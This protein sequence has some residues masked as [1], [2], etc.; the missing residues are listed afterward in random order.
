MTKGIKVL[1]TALIIIVGILALSTGFFYAENSTLKTKIKVSSTEQPAP[2]DT[3][4]TILDE[5][6]DSAATK[7][8]EK[9]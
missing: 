5:P 3:E 7:T 2:T 6:L 1:T 4:D 8:D 9:T